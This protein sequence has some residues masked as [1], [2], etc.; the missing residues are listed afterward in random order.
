MPDAFLFPGQ[1]SQQPG[2]GAEL[3]QDPDIAELAGRCSDAAS[4]DLRR[5]LTEADDDE[6]RL[7]T[8]AQP[9]L[10]FMGVALARLL[11]CR[12]VLPAAAAGHSVGEY[13]ALCVAG[14]LDAEDAVRL[15]VERGRAMAEAAPPG[16][17][18][19]AAVLGLSTEAVESALI[20]EPDVWAANYNT[21]TQVVIGGTMAGLERAA[22]RLREAGARRVL[23]LNVAAAFH[24]PLMEPAGAALRGALDAAAWRTPAVPVVANYTAEPYRDVVGVPAV[25][26]RQLSAPVRWA[27]CVR[28]LRELGC[29]RFVEVGPKRALTGMMRELV[30]EA[31]AQAISDAQSA[32][33]LQPT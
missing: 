2:M 29:D 12:D 25:L 22:Q 21:P 31:E 13:T 15:V 1:G 18:S 23:P 3:L 33:T 6:L 20:G 14:A 7:T 11:A 17:S 5:L 26:E 28:R 8:N 27:D 24:T 4:I 9:A 30:P 16:T 19:M 10:L 32:R